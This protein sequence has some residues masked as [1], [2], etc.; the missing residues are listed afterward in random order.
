[1]KNGALYP[2]L[3]SGSVFN[4]FLVSTLSNCICI[5]DKL[6]DR[7]F[8]GIYVIYDEFS[9]YLESSISTATNSDIKLPQDLPRSVTVAETSRCI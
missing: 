8:S 2:E 5:T 3:T 6:K 1:M 4:H 9:K 7:G